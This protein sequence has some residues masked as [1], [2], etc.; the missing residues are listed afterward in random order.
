MIPTPERDAWRITRVYLV[1]GSLWILFSD[2]ITEFLVADTSAFRVISITK[3]WVYVAVTAIV[4]YSL[5]KASLHKTAEAQ[6]EAIKGYGELA[7]AHEKL[8]EANAKLRHLALH[9]SLTGLPNRIALHEELGALLSDP[10]AHGALLFLDVDNFKY[11]NDSLGHAVGDELLSNLAER[12]KTYL[13][14]DW[15]LFRLGGDEYVL[16]AKDSHEAEVM[17]FVD[18]L[19][20]AMSYPFELSNTVVHISISMGITFYPA[21]GSDPETLLKHADTAMYRAKEQMSNSFVV[22]DE[23]MNQAIH[24]RLLLDQALRGALENEELSIVYQ[25]QYDVKT[26]TICGFEALLRWTNPKLGSVP[27]HRFIP[28]AEQSGLIL[29]IGDWVLKNA[30]LFLREL[31]EQG[32]SPLSMAVNVSALQLR[33]PDFTHRLFQILEETQLDPRFLEIEI[34]ESTFMGFDDGIKQKLKELRR[35]GIGIALDDFGTGYSS[36]SYLRQ[37]PITTLKIDKDFIDD[38]DHRHTISLVAGIIDVGKVLGMH[39]VAEGV[40]SHKQLELLSAHG[41]HRFQGY[42]YSR[43]L[44]PQEALDILRTNHA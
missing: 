26:A 29:S 20:Q 40:E 27:P 23:G 21:H 1:I 25:P 16:L 12:L 44:P 39:V 9:D 14:K 34:T 4:L 10:K 8:A 22:F 19:P 37:L 33:Q 7:I 3:G 36:L 35:R 18:A 42:L 28:L 15:V 5:I 32:F 24:D 43:P 13:P 6:K 17:A 2:Q 11:V 30:C 41:C 38:L 31:H